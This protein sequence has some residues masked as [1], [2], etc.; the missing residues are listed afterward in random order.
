[1]SKKIVVVKKKKTDATLPVETSSAPV[2]KY[3]SLHEIVDRKR[4][5]RM[6]YS[7]VES[8]ENFDILYD[9]GI[10]D[11]LMSFHYI[12][13]RKL[14]MTRYKELGIKFFIDSGTYS[15]LVNDEFKERTL[16]DWEEYIHQYLSWARKNKDVI[17]AIANLDIEDLVGAEK[18]Y[19]WN[20]KYFEPFML[21]TGILV[22][23]I[24]HSSLGEQGWEYY[25]SR[26][27]YTGF[28]WIADISADSGLTYGKKLLDVAKKNKSV[29]HGMGMTR[30]S[31]LTK[32]PFYTSDSTTYLVGVQYGEINWW[33]GSKMTRLKKDKWKTPEMLAKFEALGLDAEKLEEESSRELTKA[34]AI[35]FIKAQE[36]IDTKLIPRM[37]WLMAEAVKNSL[38]DLSM[39][40]TASAIAKGEL[41][42][43]PEAELRKLA[44]SLNIN[45]EYADI[46]WV[47]DCITD[48]TTFLTWEEPEYE[49][50]RPYYR[51]N[52]ELLGNIHDQY[53][54]TVRASAEEKINDL[55]QFFKDVFTGENKK[56]LNH[57]TNFDVTAKERDTYLEEDTHEEIDVSLAEY[58]EA[59]NH[60]GIDMLKLTAPK[61]SAED[62]ERLDAEIFDR[63]GMLTVRDEK[64]R[65]IKGQKRIKRPKNL[66]SDKYPKLAC[67]NCY[68]AQTCPEFKEGYVCAYHKMF[69]RFDTRNMGDVLEG[70]Q[71]LANMSLERVQKA[72]L[73][74]QLD[75]GRPTADTSQL[76]NQAM[77]MMNNINAIYENGGVI[78]KHVKRVNSDGSIE[79]TTS[80]QNPSNEK[81]GLMEKL[82]NLA[83]NKSIPEEEKQEVI[84]ADYK[85]AEDNEEEFSKFKED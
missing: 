30:T 67:N 51:D 2:H 84:D 36:Y 76:M 22:C 78:L 47:Q 35:A 7:G 24:W 81:G 26:Y 15:F 12:H 71:S 9:L 6:I 29:C 61:E 8:D 16:E 65:L 40:P 66:Y 17:F 34:N 55:I 4:L 46:Q 85:E 11:F 50:L 28:S 56:L 68:A 37:Y 73:F 48:M 25:T 19:E 63:T 18:V 83:M 54:N 1:M 57:G 27:P 69:K 31:L 74:E 38:E 33:E 64:G 52:E 77:Q 49:E 42:Q 39:L 53:I 70:M 41:S 5:F 79:E 43:M 3:S 82:F 75:G 45:G 72:M 62:I 20:K 80:V 14:S 10:R 23:F 60:M 13:K 44:T 59:V 21:E 32:L 58:V